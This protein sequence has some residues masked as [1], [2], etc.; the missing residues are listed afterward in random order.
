[1]AS[2]YSDIDQ[3][4]IIAELLK[5]SSN[6]I[7]ESINKPTKHAQN[8]DDKD[9]QTL[10]DAN[11]PDQEKLTK[12]INISNR[13]YFPLRQIQ[14]SRWNTCVIR[15][16]HVHFHMLGEEV[17]KYREYDFCLSLF[18]VQEGHIVIPLSHGRL[19]L[20]VTYDSGRVSFLH[21]C[22]YCGQFSISGFGHAK[23]V[24]APPDPR[25]I[26]TITSILIY[27]RSYRI[28]HEPPILFD[29]SYYRI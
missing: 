29:N 2:G 9:D 28:I 18:L 23:C 12:P 5:T 8:N 4:S 22:A 14:F 11:Q 26:E 3:L 16:K 10:Y 17:N 6:S 13:P 24:I 25:D 20:E 15:N 19:W 21:Q 7:A 1:M 27:G